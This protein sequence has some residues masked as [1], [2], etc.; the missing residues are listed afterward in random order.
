MLIGLCPAFLVHVFVKCSTVD[1][2]HELLTAIYCVELEHS[3]T[4]ARF[5]V[6]W[7]VFLMTTHKMYAPPAL[8]AS[9]CA[10][11]FEIQ[12]IIVEL[13]FCVPLVYTEPTRYGTAGCCG[14]GP[15][16]AVNRHVQ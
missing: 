4:I 8:R 13:L 10:F 3:A 9:R 5:R 6:D 11:C 16:P 2:P 7:T 15:S 1:Y 12:N 14:C